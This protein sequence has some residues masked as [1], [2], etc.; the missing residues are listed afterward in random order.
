MPFYNE[1]EGAKT[2]VMTMDGFFRPIQTAQGSTPDLPK[3]TDNLGTCDG[4][5]PT[6]SSGPPPPVNT[7]TP[8]PINTKFLDILAENLKAII[9]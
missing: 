2:S 3:V 6:Q 5:N 1:T 9:F 4:I 7:Q 8:L